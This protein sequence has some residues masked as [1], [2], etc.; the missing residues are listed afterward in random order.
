MVNI[1]PANKKWITLVAMILLAAYSITSPIDLK[2]M[3]P[4]WISSPTIGTFSLIN[5]AAYAVLLG[6]FWIIRKDI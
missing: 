3:L 5:I 6:A 1:T 2:S 4:A